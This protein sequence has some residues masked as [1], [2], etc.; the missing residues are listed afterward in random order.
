MPLPPG[1]LQTAAQAF[2]AGTRSAVRRATGGKR[3]KK[4]RSAA[5]NTRPA[6]RKQATGR[7]SKPR[8]GTK[9]WMAY[10]R[11]MRGKKKK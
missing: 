4:R 1:L 10:I 11:G 6:V 3:R 5:Q 9:A 8:P 7:S 2:A